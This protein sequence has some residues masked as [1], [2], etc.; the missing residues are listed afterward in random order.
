MRELSLFTGAGGGLLGTGLL[1]FRGVG[2]V[3]AAPFAQRVLLS[4]IVDG[5]LDPAP[6]FGD[7]HAF[8]REGWAQRYRGRVD[9]LSAGF[10]CPAFSVAGKR[11]GGADD[12][13]LWPITAETIAEVRPP[14]VLLENV[15]GLL[16]ASGLDA[17]GMGERAGE[18]LRFGGGISGSSSTT[19]PA[20]GSMRNGR[21]WERGK[22]A[23]VTTATAS[24]SSP[25]LPTPSA[26]SYGSSQNGS[27]SSRP[28][29]GTPSLETR[30]RTGDWMI[31]TCTASDANGSG[32]R[33][34]AGSS[35]HPG[36][37]LT[38]WL[39]GDGGKGRVMLATA[40]ARDWK[41]TSGMALEGEDGRNRKDQLARQVFAMLPTPSTAGAAGFTRDPEKRTAMSSGGH[42]KG[43]QGNELLRRVEMMLPTQKLSDANGAREARDYGPGLND[44]VSPRGSGWLLNPDW[45]EA[46]MGWPIGWT[47]PA[48]DAVVAWPWLERGEWIGLPEQYPWEPPRAIHT[49][50]RNSGRRA[51]VEAIGNGQ[52]PACVVRVLTAWAVRRAS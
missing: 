33:N 40:S 4:R 30:A 36:V 51:R 26:T 48:P 15:P 38:D 2:Y 18:P 34:T 16:T 19:L 45:E 32:S 13:N 10:P 20:S 25:M 3:E 49:R 28:S 7:I 22:W 35:A 21:L 9:L 8:L 47:N 39:R 24:G 37:S 50:A 44:L 12:R 29:A 6:I 41:D 23:R 42:R 17:R 27:N 11:L 14:L 31:P 52:V 43:H 1:G 5:L 46:H